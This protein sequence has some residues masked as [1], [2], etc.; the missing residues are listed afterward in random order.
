MAKR[1]PGNTDARCIQDLGDLAEGL[2]A[3]NERFSPDFYIIIENVR[4]VDG[5]QRTFVA[6]RCA[7]VAIS[8]L[9]NDETAN[10]SVVFCTFVNHTSKRDGDAAGRAVTNPALRAADDKRTIVLTGRNGR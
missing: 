3:L 7:S 4:L 9:W 10:F 5:T 6:D 8:I 1:G 2:D